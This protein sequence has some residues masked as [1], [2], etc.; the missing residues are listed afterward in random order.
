MLGSVVASSGERMAFVASGYAVR[1]ASSTRPNST[2]NSHRHVPMAVAP[3]RAEADQGWAGDGHQT[4]S[5]IATTR[6]EE[7]CYRPPRHVDLHPPSRSGRPSLPRSHFSGGGR[8]CLQCACTAHHPMHPA[9]E[10]PRSI[11]YFHSRRSPPPRAPRR[12]QQHLQ[13]PNVGWRFSSKFSARDSHLILF[14]GGTGA[15]AS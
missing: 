13:E 10:D 3:A 5:C 15:D 8:K 7:C 4:S 11:S 2:V 6:A 9:R 12:H 14:A 1:P